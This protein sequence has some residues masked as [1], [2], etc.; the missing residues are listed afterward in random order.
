MKR[1]LF[2]ICFFFTVLFLLSL[3]SCRS[4][5][6]YL[7][8][9]ESEKYT[10]NGLTPNFEATIQPD[11]I[12]QISIVSQNPE[13]AQAFNQK[14]N[15]SDVTNKNIQAQGFLVNKDGFISFP[16]LGSI[17]VAGY[18][19]SAL[20]E[21]LKSRVSPYVTD[22]EVT[23][24]VLNFKI[25]VLGEVG[26]PG[27]VT[28][29]SDR[30][31]ILEAIAQSG[32]LTIQSVRKNILIIRD[33]QGQKSFTRVDITRADIVNSPFYYLKQ[34]DVIYV[35]PRRAK[36]DATALGPYLTS[37]AS[38]ISLGLTIYFILQ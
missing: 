10:P 37:I 35:E 6:E 25:T 27:V 15:V 13:A 16:I 12:L 23:I 5:K 38:I 9:Q 22:A 1:S 33:N 11:D 31:T 32:D 34:N 19:R 28:V 24:S 29:N 17:K 4:P 3:T 8:L 7:Y 30:I 14:Q 36:Y 2:R 26:S 21:N 18:T 20:V